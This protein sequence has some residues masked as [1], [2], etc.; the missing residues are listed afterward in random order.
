LLIVGLRRF[1]IANFQLEKRAV[2]IARVDPRAFPLT[3]G[4][5]K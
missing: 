4:N 2:L 3:L 5:W 1:L